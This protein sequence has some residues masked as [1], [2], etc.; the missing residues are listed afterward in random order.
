VL[1]ALDLN[2]TDTLRAPGKT[3][4]RGLCSICHSTVIAHCGPVQV[5]HWQHER[6]DDCDSWAEPAGMTDWHL[7][8]QREVP[9]DRREVVI[10]SHRADIVTPGGRVCEIQHSLLGYEAIEAREACYGH[11]ML[12]IFDARLRD[13]ND[14]PW[15]HRFASRRS[16]PGVWR[17]DW[18]QGKWPLE[19]CQ[20]T[21]LLDRGDNLLQ[22]TELADDGLSGFAVLVTREQIVAVLNIPNTQLPEL[23]PK[24]PPP[25]YI[26]PP[27]PYIPPPPPYIPPPLATPRWPNPE[28]RRPYIA[29]QKVTEW[30][31]A[32]QPAHPTQPVVAPPA[33]HWRERLARGIPD[34]PPIW[35]PERWAEAVQE[36]HTRRATGEAP[37]DRNG[38]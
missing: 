6:R 10:G 4:D 30:A 29:P 17:W 27:P 25:P 36:I 3:G 8:W 22:V 38:D 16:R 34:D 18:K 24:P 35:T 23:P 9:L 21:V 19:A 11:D 5:W 2:M 7:N 14:R 26:P 15:A 32:P 37:N 31:P 20:G 33:L 28:A 13:D 12:W 1:K